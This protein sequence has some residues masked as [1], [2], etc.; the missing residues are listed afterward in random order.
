MIGRGMSLH[1]GV[2]NN[3]NQSTGY[4]GSDEVCFPPTIGS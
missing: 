3:F 2:T 4:G 1:V